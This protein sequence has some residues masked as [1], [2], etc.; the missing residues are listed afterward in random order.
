MTSLSL[1]FIPAL[2][3]IFGFFF[4]IAFFPVILMIY[5]LVDIIRSRFR[6][7]TIQILFAVMVIFMPLIGSI[8]YLIVRR[9][10]KI[11]SY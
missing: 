6:D 1:L 3:E 10:Q 2:F 7:Q 5:C 4:L 8:I 11:S 9:D